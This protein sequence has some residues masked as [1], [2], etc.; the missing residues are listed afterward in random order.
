MNEHTEGK[1]RAAGQAMKIMIVN[2]HVLCRSNRN[3]GNLKIM[4]RR[5]W[6]RTTPYLLACRPCRYSTSDASHVIHL[7]TPFYC[8][9][10]PT[11]VE[12]FESHML[13]LGGKNT[14]VRKYSGDITA[15]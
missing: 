15:I 6:N 5:G 7:S 14:V 3:W 9:P 4:E 11:D 1:L 8:L 2:Y 10:V 12:V 13:T